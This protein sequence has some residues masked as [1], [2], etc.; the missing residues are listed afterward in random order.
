MVWHGE[1]WTP[2]CNI[3]QDTPTMLSGEKPAQKTPSLGTNS[4]DMQALWRAAALLGWWV[5]P[6]S[7][8]GRRIRSDKKKIKNTKNRKGPI[9]Q[10]V[11]MM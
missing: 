7:A 10:Q 5:S 1:G 9:S 4:G 6:S 11:E 3:A 8:R 2:P